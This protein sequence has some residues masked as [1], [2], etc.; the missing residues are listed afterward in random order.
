MYDMENLNSLA[1]VQSKD[2]A[3]RTQARERQKKLDDEGKL[4]RKHALE[5]MSESG[6]KKKKRKIDDTIS[7][8]EKDTSDF[9]QK[10]DK[11]EEEDATRHAELLDQAKETTRAVQ[12][13]CKLWEEE[14]QDMRDLIRTLVRRYEDTNH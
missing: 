3:V 6:G 12:Q 14:R 1:E 4:M 10:I 11:M 13:L 5:G 7:S 2:P 9:Q 8:L